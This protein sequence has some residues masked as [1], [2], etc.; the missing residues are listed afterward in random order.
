M[1]ELLEA[2]SDCEIVC[3]SG[4][5]SSIKV[6]DVGLIVTDADMDRGKCYVLDTHSY[7]RV[8]YVTIGTGDVED[9]FVKGTPEFE[10]VMENYLISV[11]L[12]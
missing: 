7:Y 2:F 10:K 11:A 5:G 8:R 1:S 3:G 4:D 9:H 12:K 6:K